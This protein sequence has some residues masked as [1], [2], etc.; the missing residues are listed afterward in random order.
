[1]RSLWPAYVFVAAVLVVPSAIVAQQ[2]VISPLPARPTMRPYPRPSYHPGH[3]RPPN[4]PGYGYSNNTYGNGA[5]LI[6]GSVVN[7]YL[8]T[9]APVPMPKHKATPRPKGAPDVFE[10]H[11]TDDNSQ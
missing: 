8:R 10:E 7:R 4:R 6:D 11:S 5:V 2:P 3:N 1:M 9:P